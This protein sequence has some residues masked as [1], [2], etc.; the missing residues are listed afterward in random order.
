MTTSTTVEVSTEVCGHVGWITLNRPDRMN[1]INVALAERLGAALRDLGGRAEVHAIGIRGA[2]GNFCAGG[3]F[4]EVRRLR[5]RGPDALRTLFVAFKDACD[6]IAGLP[7]PVVAA[8]QG[9]AMAGGFEL[10]Q[11]ADVV[12]VA[13]DARLADNHV[14]F[15]MIPGGG[16]TVRLPR[17]VGR[18]LALGLLLSG[19]RIG[20]LDAV[21][22]GLAYRS[23][24]PDL[25]DESVR[26][27]LETLAGRD[28]SA[29][30]T[31]KQ[32]V[33]HGLASEFDVANRAETDAVVARL[34]G[35]AGQAGVTAF[36][37]RE[38]T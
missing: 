5:A 16:S 26:T 2:G 15:G 3:D 35:V 14:N 20:G 34:S 8:V 38:T 25:F 36:E 18:Q 29:V 23:F 12:L 10:L 7:V 33:T 37:N 13:D 9:V 17:I 28:R 27:F 30:T 21:R 24:R 31:I 6:V 32:L 22:M 19:D 1:A 4:D 11:A